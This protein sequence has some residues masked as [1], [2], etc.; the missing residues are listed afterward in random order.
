MPEILSGLE[1]KPLI[2]QLTSHLSPSDAL[3][4]LTVCWHNWQTCCQ[5]H[6]KTHTSRSVRF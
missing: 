1:A 2:A 6:P 3:L 5:N 4:F